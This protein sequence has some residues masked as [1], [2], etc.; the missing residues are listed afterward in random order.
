LHKVI[1]LTQNYKLTEELK[2]YNS[3]N[4]E[5]LTSCNQLEILRNTKIAIYHGGSNTV[6]E[7]LVNGIYH[8]LFPQ[9]VEQRH[10]AMKL[11]ELGLAHIAR[12]N[13]VESIMPLI[14]N[15]E[16]NIE[17]I[18][19]LQFVKELVNK[20]IDIREVEEKIKRLL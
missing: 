12:E 2:E 17:L 15:F 11:E 8:I 3:K 7:C 9:Q 4:I 14:D 10:N 19:K 20:E 6:S 13:K 5:I 1:I 16:K 18:K